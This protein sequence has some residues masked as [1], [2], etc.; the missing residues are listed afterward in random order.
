M[1]KM[2]SVWMPMP[3]NLTIKTTSRMTEVKEY[4]LH[5]ALL[6]MESVSQLQM[7]VE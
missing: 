5:S 2:K 3:S 4:F 6:K 1:S 7:V